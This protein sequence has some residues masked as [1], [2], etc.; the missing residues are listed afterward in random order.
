M[1]LNRFI[2]AVAATAGVA[3]A[4][5]IGIGS[6]SSALANS[7]D[8]DPGL[9]KCYKYMYHLLNGTAS[10]KPDGRTTY[11]WACAERLPNGRINKYRIDLS[12]CMKKKGNGIFVVRSEREPYSWYCGKDKLPQD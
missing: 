8:P 6:I 10:I 12:S 9:D 3:F 5:S 2:K 4:S 7:I 1:N 11:D